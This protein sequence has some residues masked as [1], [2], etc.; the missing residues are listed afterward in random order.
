MVSGRLRCLCC[1]LPVRVLEHVASKAGE[2]HGARIAAHQRT[3]DRIRADRRS[4][5]EKPAAAAAP[6]A[7]QR[8]VYDAGGIEQLPGHLVRKEGAA[9]VKDVAVNQAWDNLGITLDFFAKVFGRDSLDGRGMNVEASVHYGEGFSNAMW[10]G[11]EMLFGDGDGVH[12]LGFTHSLDIVAHELTHAVT[13]HAIPGGLGQ[14]RKGGKVELV[15]QAGA[16]NESISDV[17]ASMVK[18]W[19]A[20]Q[21]VVKADWLLGEG[22]LAPGLGRAVR[23]LKEPGKRSSTYDGDDQ[24]GDMT[25]YVEGA[26]VHANSGIANHAFYLA[27]HTLGGHSWE[28][29]GRAWYEAIPLLK[30]QSTF[31]DAAH[32]TIEAA[33]RLFGGASKEQHAVR[34]AWEEVK[35]LKG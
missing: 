10:T 32:A 3:S 18:Q 11:R 12:I 23:S 24:V 27:A 13:Q 17:F 2:A 8:F 9:A 34:M 19:H 5:A 1:A 20:K 25:A 31:R 16:L 29:A 26:D 15:G 7:R 30:P 14:V 6:A 22:I 4:R 33:G 28:H 21:D 35:V